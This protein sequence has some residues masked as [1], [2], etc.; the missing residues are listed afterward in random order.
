MATGKKAVYYALLA[1]AG[2]ALTKT[3]AALA[4]GSSAMMAEAIHSFADCGNQLLL[5]L[6]MQRA[7]R[8]ATA[9][10]PLGYGK[11][12]YFWSFMVALLLFSVGGLFSI[13]EGLHKLKQPEPL[14][15][16]WLAIAVLGIGIVLESFSLY[17]AL[18]EIRPL[19]GERSLYRWF[20]ETR[21]SELMV[22]T[23][24]DIAALLGLVAAL[25]FI[26]LA[27]YTGNP[28]FD[29]VGSIV[30]GALLIV[31]ATSIT[32]EI[33]SLMIGESADEEFQKSLLEFLAGKYPNLEVLRLITQHYGKDIVLAIKAK[34]RRWPKG[35][36]ELVDA[37]NVIEKSIR[38]E[39]PAVR[40]IFFEPDLS[41][42]EKRRKAARMQQKMP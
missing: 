29:A 31:I 27:L 16:P 7:E 40:F 15:Y 25:A 2:I 39:F 22:V 32:V 4:T 13:Y 34:F 6:G 23:G 14:Q 11:V 20:R 30:I 3:A 17:G 28:T 33:K 35:A 8:P 19:R 36:R 10:H 41:P 21:A 12:S 18:R 24:E 37:I 38:A 42:E 5:L 9:L 1:N 26:G